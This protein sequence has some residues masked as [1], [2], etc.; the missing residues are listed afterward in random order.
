MRYSEAKQGRVFVIRLEDGDVLHESI[1]AFARE[2]EI[3]AAGL[4]ALGG[5]R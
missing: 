1:E 2:H 5:S 3:Q 4:I